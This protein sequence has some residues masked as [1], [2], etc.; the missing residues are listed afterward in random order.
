MLLSITGDTNGQPDVLVDAL[1]ARGHQ[2]VRGS[3]DV[4]ARFTR[5]AVDAVILNLDAPNKSWLSLLRRFRTASQVPVLVWGA[6]REEYPPARWLAGGA[7]DY[8]VKPARTEDLITRIESLRRRQ[9]ARVDHPRG[10][11]EI[12]DIS[13]DL[14]TRTVLVNEAPVQLTKIEFDVLATLARRAGASVS[15]QEITF[16]VWG[17]TRRPA[18]RSLDTHMA[19]LRAKLGRAD[20]LRTLYGYGYQLG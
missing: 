9:P 8:L 1:R 2:L 18:S 13:I 5:D 19:N 15:R 20:L 3:L 10:L 12:A 17:S 4:E 16:D 7:D 14:N 11:V 6:R